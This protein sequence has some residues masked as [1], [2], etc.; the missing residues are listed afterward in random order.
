[1]DK[2]GVNKQVNKNFSI[3]PGINSSVMETIIEMAGSIKSIGEIKKIIKIHAQECLNLIEQIEKEGI[4]DS[5]IAIN[6]LL[7][8]E[9]IRNLNIRRSAFINLMSRKGLILL[10]LP[11]HLSD[12]FLVVAP[13]DLIF[14]TDIHVP[15]HLKHAHYKN[16]SFVPP[17]ELANQVKRIESVVLEGYIEENEI[18]I[19]RPAAQLIYQLS[20]ANLK[21]IFI[22]GMPHIPPHIQFIKLDTGGI[23]LKIHTI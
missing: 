11:P 10:P 1:M 6:L 7:I 23:E 3:L 9:A 4:V 2:R 13:S 8:D 21:E 12:P 22:H 5:Q 16:I 17:G 14:N 18:Y 19:R 20:F 15:P